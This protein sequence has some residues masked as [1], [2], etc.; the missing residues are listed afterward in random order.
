MVAVITLTATILAHATGLSEVIVTIITISP[1]AANW[2]VLQYP[3]VHRLIVIAA[4]YEDS[5]AFKCT[6]HQY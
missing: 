6:W 4:H 3:S 1:V 2:E 5:W